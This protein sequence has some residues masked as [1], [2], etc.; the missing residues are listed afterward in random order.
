MDFVSWHNIPTNIALGQQTHFEAKKK[1]KIIA[2]AVSMHPQES[3]TL[4]SSGIAS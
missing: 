1:K 2:V 4:Q 3:P